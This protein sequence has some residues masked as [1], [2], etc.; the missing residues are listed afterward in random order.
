MKK[1]IHII[2]LLMALTALFSGCTGKTEAAASQPQ[3]S[4][5]QEEQSVSDPAPQGTQSASQDKAVKSNIMG[6]V[7]SINGSNIQL[8]LIE[9]PQFGPGGGQR[10]QKQE[11]AGDQNNQPPDAKSQNGNPPSDTPPAE[12]ESSDNSGMQRGNPPQGGQMNYTGETKTI[13][14][15]DDAEIISQG[16]SQDGSENQTL[17]LKDIQVGN[18]LRIWYEDEQN[19]VISKISVMTSPGKNPQKTN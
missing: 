14:V 3:V 13:I 15:S 17:A 19:G 11:S 8:K 2:I 5:N 12:N 18:I 7:A 9:M 4:S 10:G 1:T 6:E 16:R